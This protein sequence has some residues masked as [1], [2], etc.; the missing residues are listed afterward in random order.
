MRK[1]LVIASLLALCAANGVVLA[2]KVYKWTD[3][4]G[5]VHYSNTPPAAAS[6]HERTVLDEH[7][8]VTDVLEAPMTPEEIAAAEKRQAELERQ[9]RL[10]AE[11]AAKDNMLLQT[12]TAV[13]EMEMARDGRINALDAQ[14]RVVSGAISS[15]QSHLADLGDRADTV[16]AGGNPVP[17]ALQQEIEATRAELLDNQKFLI[18]RKEEQ[19]QIREKFAADIA[20]FKELK[21]L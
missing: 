6:Q 12:Y 18:A 13:D 2:G 8:N 20:R 10:A 4:D 15:L 21:G 11:Q 19:E 3:K 9:K 16:R 1:L 17:E 5:N 7:G 14:I